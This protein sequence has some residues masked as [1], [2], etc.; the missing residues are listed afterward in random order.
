MGNASLTHPTRDRTWGAVIPRPEAQIQR[1]FC[2][3]GAQPLFKKRLLHAFLHFKFR[4]RLLADFLNADIRG[5]VD[6]R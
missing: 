3:G 4:P 5:V 2:A 1:S 6:Q